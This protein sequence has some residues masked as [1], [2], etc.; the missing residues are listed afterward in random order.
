MFYFLSGLWFVYVTGLFL[1]WNLVTRT[2]EKREGWTAHIMTATWP[3]TMAAALCAA[4]FAL[5]KER[6]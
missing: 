1:F 5:L 3:V 6:S 2:G 4:Y